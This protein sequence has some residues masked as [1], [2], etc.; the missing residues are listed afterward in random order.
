MAIHV[1]QGTI[2]KFTVGGTLTAVSQLLEVDGPE[3]TVETKETT[4]LASTSKSYRAQLPDGG[5]VSGKVQYDPGDTTHQ[6][7]TTAINQWPQAPIACSLV[8]NTATISTA[9]FSA[10]L[11]KFKPVGMNEEDNLEAEIEWKITGLV[12][13]PTS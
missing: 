5:N 9:A 13:W 8:F 10:I 11:T 4:N 6:A 12:T 2:L 1:G 7:F 3:A